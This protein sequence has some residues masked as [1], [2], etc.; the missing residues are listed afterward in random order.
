[1]TNLLHYHHC[2]QEDKNYERE[3]TE[4]TLFM[5]TSFFL[6]CQHHVSGKNIL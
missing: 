2:S 5:T 6:R 1:M 4:F 3:D